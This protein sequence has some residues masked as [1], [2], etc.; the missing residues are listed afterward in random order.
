MRTFRILI[1]SFVLMFSY[2]YS[3][4]Q[5]LSNKATISLLIASLDPEHIVSSYGHTLLRVQ[6]PELNV[7]Y[8][9]NYGTFDQS[10]TG[11]QTF[12]G[13][14][15][16]KLEYEIWVMPFAEYY[17]ATLKEDRTLVEHTFNFSPEEKKAIW[18]NLIA[19]VKDK[20]KKYRFDFFSQNCT[21]FARDFITYNLGVKIVLP[22]DLG[23][24]T[25]RDINVKYVQNKL[26]Y[27]FIIDLLAGNDLDNK[28]TAYQSLYEPRELEKAW[29]KSFI[30]NTNG[31]Q[32][33]LFAS[34]AVL[35]KGRDFNDQR[36]SFLFS[37][38][39]L[40]IVVL[41]F[42]LVVSVVEWKNKAFYKKVDI[43]LFGIAGL[44]GSIFYLFKF[45]CGRWYVLMDWDILWLHPLH[46][47]VA[48]FLI[49]FFNKS[50]LV[51]HYIN[52][53]LLSSLIIGMFLFA[54][55]YNAAIA[56]FT[57]GLLVR[58]IAFMSN[59]KLQNISKINVSST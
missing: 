1:L 26:W 27:L 51:Y 13:I 17:Q 32:K 19:T 21:T 57:A 43:T 44:L 16:S 40:S 24:K 2:S 49:K 23:S 52:A 59:G 14:V 56:V 25:Y 35:I 3:T 39:F 46:L 33:T 38:L 9:I 11:F 5:E 10:L 54:Q 22:A 50:L 28:V 55:S 47:L 15:R 18:Q 58:S 30:T 12:M 37:P 36:T 6:D 45:V 7:D 41:L 20:D 29:S 34:T 31:H 4:A 8:V 53:L 48:L 42:I